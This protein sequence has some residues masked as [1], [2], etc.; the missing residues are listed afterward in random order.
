MALTEGWQREREALAREREALEL[1]LT[2][3]RDEVERDRE[4]WE[5]KEREMDEFKSASEQEILESKALVECER[6]AAERA[7]VEAQRQSETHVQEIARLVE[8]LAAANSIQDQNRHVLNEAADELGSIKSEFQSAGDDLRRRTDLLKSQHEIF[9][10]NATESGELLACKEE[11]IANLKRELS[12][13]QA[14]NQVLDGRCIDCEEQAKMAEEI[15]D[16]DRKGWKQDQEDVL[17]LEAEVETLRKE[18]AGD[19]SAGD[20]ASDTIDATTAS[21]HTIDAT[22][23]SRAKTSAAGEFYPI[24]SLSSA[25]R[26]T[27]DGAPPAPALLHILLFNPC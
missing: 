16:Q 8:E 14:A 11:M 19:V 3:I 27:L 6:Q 23:A 7:A 5:Q 9:E 12:A 26:S 13:L 21:R 1:A 18:L 4:R 22:A 20:R 2:R 17:R 10:R 25:G 24:C 15:A